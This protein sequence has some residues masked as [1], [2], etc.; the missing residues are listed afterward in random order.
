MWQAAPAPSAFRE[1]FDLQRGS[2]E[3][4]DHT[5]TRAAVMRGRQ[6]V[7]AR[8][9]AGAFAC[10]ISFGS[11]PE[12]FYRDFSERQRQLTDFGRARRSRT[13]RAR[14]G[15]LISCAKPPGDL[16]EVGPGHGTLALAAKEAGWRY[17]AIEA[18]PPD[19]ER[20]RTLLTE[21]SRHAVPLD[22]V[23]LA[24]AAERAIERLAAELERDP[25]T[26]GRIR[27]LSALVELAGGV[28]P[29]PFATELVPAQNVFYAL[30]HKVRSRMAAKAGD[31]DEEGRRASEWL[32]AFDELGRKLRVRVS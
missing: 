3:I 6:V 26:L 31:S 7:F 29:Q 20:A 15:L 16:V 18:S 21:A 11:M 19:L 9:R 10:R 30:L 14:L 23:T 13:E 4:G 12:N 32:G 25:E 22:H 5:S 28:V 1:D 24:F 17:R 27:D 2:R 8:L